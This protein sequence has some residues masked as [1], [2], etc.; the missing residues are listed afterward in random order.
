MEL[1]EELS[2]L[3]KQKFEN[4]ETEFDNRLELIESQQEQLENA[5]KLTETQG[6]LV[7]TSYYT[8]LIKSEEKIMKE[9][10][11][12]RTE[13]QNSLNEAV[14]SGRVEEYSEAWYDMKGAINDVN[15]AIQESE[16]SLE[17][18]E[19]EIRQLEWDTFDYLAD[20]ISSAVDEG[21]FLIELLSKKDLFQQ[22]GDHKGKITN[23][24]MAVLGQYAVNYNLEMGKADKYA[25]EIE[26]INKSLESDPYNKDLIERREELLE[27][28]RESILNAEEEKEAMIDLVKEGVELQI[29][30]MQD[31]IDKKNE[32][33]DKEKELYDYQKS[34]EEKSKRVK[35]IEKQLSSIQGDDSEENRKNIQEL[36]NQLKE[37][38]E[39]LS[40]AEYDKWLSDQSELMDS[41][42]ES[43][44]ETLNARFDDTDALIND[45]IN[46]T[47]ENR[48]IINDTIQSSTEN[49][50]YTVTEGMKDIWSTESG[51]GQVVSNYANN[52]NEHATTVQKYLANID[53]YFTSMKQK[54]DE[55][56]KKKQE[57]IANQ[58]KPKPPVSNGSSSKPPVTS[59]NGKGDGVA[60]VGDSVT[61]SNGKY[62]YDS[63]GTAPAGSQLLG[64]TVYITRV[65]NKSWATKPYHISRDKA[66]KHPLGWV[67]LSQIKGYKDGTKNATQG[68]HF[69]DEEGLGSEVIV[70]KKGALR[71]LDSGDN[72][73]NK[74]IVENLYDWGAIN[75][76]DILH[77]PTLSP[78]SK[79]LS[80]DIKFNFGDV[81]LQ[82][83]QNP[84]QFANELVYVT[85]KYPKVQ[86]AMQA[87]TVDRLNGGSKLGVNRIF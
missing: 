17:E 11:D 66:G 67:S 5:I 30:A 8:S 80:N 43:Y 6:L 35:D 61:F 86:N 78:V 76:T 63:Q 36:Q 31:L 29:E 14:N 72:V 3:A 1:N 9:L 26:K 60:R 13:L 22:K 75:P 49:V 73:F 28:Q 56:A 33:L 7:S 44:D 41:M 15:T 19:N 27:L 71:Q 83:V 82:D 55:E 25:A 87:V 77:F 23:E 85:K 37:A 79:N 62:Y 34:I 53:A 16:I 51:L 74:G 10:M 20:T 4:I 59:N 40:D 69:T 2:E 57:Q 24:G 42:L 64:Q 68:L 58:N 18:F 84:E 52:F 70:T 54:A 38:K 48:D 21:N 12:K 81:I 46:S 47:N 39:D 50:G 32:A 45:L 65:N